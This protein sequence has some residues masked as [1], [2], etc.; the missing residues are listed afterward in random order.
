[1]VNGYVAFLMKLK[2]S[3][4]VQWFLISKLVDFSPPLSETVAL[5]QNTHVN[6]IPCPPSFLNSSFLEKT[7]LYTVDIKQQ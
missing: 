5:N 7:V 6:S 2:M 4:V 1:M 3:S